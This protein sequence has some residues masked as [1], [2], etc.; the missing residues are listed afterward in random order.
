MKHYIFKK[1]VISNIQQDRK[2]DI[3]IIATDV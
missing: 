3:V 1:N 2:Y